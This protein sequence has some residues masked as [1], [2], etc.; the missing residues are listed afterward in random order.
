MLST[1]QNE[2]FA[3]YYQKD[4]D[5]NTSSLSDDDI[6]DIKKLA[7]EKRVDYALAPMGT[8]VFD[9]ILQQNSH[10]RFE[11]VAFDSEKIDG[12]LYIPEN[13]KEN[14]YIILNSKKP[15]INQ[16]FTAAHE[17]YHYI[18][19]YQ[20]FKDNPCICDFSALKDVNEMKASRFAAE[21]LL[22]E[23]TLAREI[24]S[25]LRAIG[26]R[27]I[28]EADFNSLAALHI[29]L[30]LKYQ[31][32]LK[33]VIYRFHEE[34]Y[35]DNISSLIDNYEFIKTV[36][37][38]ITIYDKQVKELYGTENNYVVPYSSTYQDMER[39]YLAGNASREEVLRD[40]ALLGLNMGL[41]NGF[42]EE[43]ADEEDVVDDEELF[44]LVKANWGD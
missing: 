11:M 4:Y 40:A 25:S 8:D 9:W 10:I 15:L 22:P 27:S 20:K 21:I 5:F 32:P 28:K 35:L 13:G 16:I 7:R 37:Q 26:R 3:Q 30:T 2:L 36:L 29:Y 38:E 24:R 44:S 12:L 18:M 1:D 17:F 43:P 34:G 14:A 33:A 31:M 23:E 42:W 19:D 6:A 39:A 41:V